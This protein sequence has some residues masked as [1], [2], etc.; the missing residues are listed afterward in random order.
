MVKIE[1][2]R[3]L[4]IKFGIFKQSPKL[5]RLRHSLSDA[6]PHQHKALHV[7]AAAP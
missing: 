4:E 2:K 7:F 1:E 6:V 3:K 5:M